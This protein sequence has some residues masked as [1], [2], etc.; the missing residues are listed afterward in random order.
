MVPKWL[1]KG[2]NVTLDVILSYDM[3]IFFKYLIT[4]IIK[5]WRF[6]QNSYSFS[7]LFGSQKWTIPRQCDRVSWPSIRLSMYVPPLQFSTL[8]TT[9]PAM[10]CIQIASITASNTKSELANIS[11]CVRCND[12][13]AR[14]NDD[15]R[16]RLINGRGARLQTG[17]IRDTWRQARH[18][19]F[20][21]PT[22][23]KP[24][25]GAGRVQCIL[26]PVTRITNILV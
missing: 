15:C 22:I 21:W 3:N 16:A 10:F 12:S 20:N 4:H 1:Y 25:S 8:V 13:C 2:K 5:G 19:L 18:P 11:K 24:A 7:S 6:C 26:I 14:L 23:W 9:T 17:I